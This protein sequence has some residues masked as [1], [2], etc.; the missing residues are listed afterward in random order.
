MHFFATVMEG[1]SGIEYNDCAVLMFIPH[2][3]VRE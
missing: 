2:E 1:F 3:R